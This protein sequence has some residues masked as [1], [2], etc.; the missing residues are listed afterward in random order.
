MLFV[1]AKVGQLAR[2]PQGQAERDSRAKSMVD[3]MD[4]EGFGNCTNQG[5][6]EAVCPKDIKIKYIS[7]LNL[8]YTRS[9][10]TG[11]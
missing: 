10:L 8:E 11:K 2:L 1:S 5:E 6:C 9:V 4:E 3:Q 7:E